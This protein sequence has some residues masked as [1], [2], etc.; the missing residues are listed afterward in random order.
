MEGMIVAKASEASRAIKGAKMIMP[1]NPYL[2]QI[3]EKYNIVRNRILNIPVDFARDYMPKTSDLIELQD[4][5]GNKWN[6]RCIRRKMQM[7]LSK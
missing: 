6:V 4:S 3:L 1:E 7:F 5:D 2:L